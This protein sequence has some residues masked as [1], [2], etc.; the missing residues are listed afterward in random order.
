MGSSG[1]CQRG[2]PLLRKSNSLFR[3]PLS[4]PLEDNPPA[5]LEPAMEQKQ[6]CWGWIR[7]EE[8][9]GGSPGGLG[10]CEGTYPRGDEGAAEA[11]S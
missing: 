8:G 2:R 5:S 1:R 6:L 9:G 7:E 4:Q 11:C 3:R 10:R